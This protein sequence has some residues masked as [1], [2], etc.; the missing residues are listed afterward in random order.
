MRWNAESMQEIKDVSV[1]KSTIPRASVKLGV[2][3]RTI[4]RRVAAYC[5]QG[6]ASFIHGNTNRIPANKTPLTSLSKQL[7]NWISVDVTLLS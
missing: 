5:E 7:M 1:G 3:P 4:K 2:D 6:E